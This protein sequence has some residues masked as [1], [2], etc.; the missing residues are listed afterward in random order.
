MTINKKGFVIVLLI[1]VFLIIFILVGVVAWRWY[2]DPN[3]PLQIP[4][5]PQTIGNYKLV[6][7]S[8]KGSNAEPVCNEFGSHPDIVWTNLSGELCA[9]GIRIEYFDEQTNKGV[10]VMLTDI[11][12][13]I[14]LYKKYLSLITK[15]VQVGE[16]RLL[17]LES[18]EIFWY[19]P[20]GYDVIM[21][22]EFT[23]EAL[24]EGGYKNNYGTATGDNAVTQYFLKKYE[25]VS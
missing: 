2:N 16:F 6:E 9:R 15:P 14:D 21:T 17:R 23:R 5:L 10:F 25:H 22:Q 3:K 24:P 1:I 20:K 7:S 12:R 18:H 4:S 13:G 11:T 8:N 19:T